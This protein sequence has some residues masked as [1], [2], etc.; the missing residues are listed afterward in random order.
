MRRCLKPVE[1]EQLLSGAA[2]ARRVAAWRAHLSRCE[3]CTAALAKA[4]ANESWL[5]RIR[6]AQELEELRR[7]LAG[8]AAGVAGLTSGTRVE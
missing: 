3:A 5:N 1:I 7:R 4:E 6:E 8:R 2:S